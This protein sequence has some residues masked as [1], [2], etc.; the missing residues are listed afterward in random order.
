MLIQQGRHKAQEAK[1]VASVRQQ[2]VQGQTPTVSPTQDLGIAVRKG[3][4]LK[5]AVKLIFSRYDRDGT[6]DIDVGELTEMVFDFQCS[7]PDLYA[8]TT[9]M[10][11]RR[12]ARD[13]IERL[14]T[15]GN[16]ELDSTEFYSWLAAGIDMS[17]KQR[18]SF[19]E[20]GP[21]KAQMTSFLNSVERYVIITQQKELRA[22]ESVDAVREIFT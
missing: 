15:D 13:V 5:R 6:G 22:R 11:P 12:V 9:P 2:V 18:E 21:L 8:M 16:G 10:S 1:V 19:A 4:D 20:K 3:Q 7:F 17:K 14:D